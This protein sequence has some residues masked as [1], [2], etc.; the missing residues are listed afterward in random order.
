MECPLRG[1]I[2]KSHV[3][4]CKKPV[5]EHIPSI[6]QSQYFEPHP[7]KLDSMRINDV[8]MV[9]RIPMEYDHCSSKW[10]LCAFSESYTNAELKRIYLCRLMNQITPQLHLVLRRKFNIFVR[11]FWFWNIYF[12]SVRGVVEDYRRL[13]PRTF[14]ESWRPWEV[15]A[16]RVDNKSLIVPENL[17]LWCWS[18]FKRRHQVRLAFKNVAIVW[19]RV[20]LVTFG[21]VFER[22]F[23]VD[24]GGRAVP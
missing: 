10:S 15:K 9:H 14:F 11:H 17:R 4:L 1:R 12:V 24:G 23:H 5:R 16:M 20:L 21:D 19:E 18:N 2:Y 6:F 7:A 22:V 8:P 3:E 13:W